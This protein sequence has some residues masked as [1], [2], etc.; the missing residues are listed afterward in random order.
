M[1][2]PS[3]GPPEP[4]LPGRR[5][6][7][8]SVGGP[9][10]R[11]GGVRV[12]VISAAP[13]VVLRL[14][15][16]KMAVVTLVAAVLLGT[17]PVVAAGAQGLGTEPG[18]TIVAQDPWLQ[19]DGRFT[20]QV[21]IT[22]PTDGYRLIGEVGPARSEMA[23]VL[24]SNPIEQDESHGRFI[25]L[26]LPAGTGTHS[27]S[28]NVAAVDTEWAPGLATDD[29]FVLDTGVYPLE[30]QVQDPDGEPVQRL[31]TH[32]PFLGGAIDNGVAP[33]PVG[34]LVDLRVGPQRTTDGRPRLDAA[35]TRR[36]DR[37][38][39]AL[40]AFADVGVSVQINPETISALVETRAGSGGGALS[41]LLQLAG[42][43][44]RRQGE[45]LNSTYVGFDEGAWLA[46][47]FDDVLRAELDAGFATLR[48][49]EFTTSRRL[50]ALNAGADEALMARCFDFGRDR[51][52]LA[53]P[54]TTANNQR[55]QPDGVSLGL[56]PQ[57]VVELPQQVTLPAADTAVEPLPRTA[58]LGSLDAYR[59]VAALLVDPISGRGGGAQ[60]RLGSAVDLDATFASTLLRLLAQRGPLR[61]T[62]ISDLFDQEQHYS[63]PKSWSANPRAITETVQQ[64]GQLLAGVNHRLAG[65]RSMLDV[66]APAGTEG[67][68]ETTGLRNTET[69]PAP[70]TATT[71]TTNSPSPLDQDDR[72]TP[73]GVTDE[74][75]PVENTLADELDARL[76]LVPAGG[77]SDAIANG[78][79]SGVAETVNAMI[80]G[81]VLPAAQSFRVTAHRATLPVV[82]LH[83]GQRPMRVALRLSSPEV[84]F[85]GPN[86]RIVVLQPGAN[87]VGVPIRTRRSGEF[88]VTIDVTSPDGA[89]LMGSIP[90]EVQSRAISG[91]GMF[92]SIGA[93]TF[94]LVWWAR[95][96]RRRRRVRNL[97]PIRHPTL[98]ANTSMDASTI[99]RGLEDAGAP[100]AGLEAAAARGR[101][102]P[103]A[104]RPST[105][106]SDQPLPPT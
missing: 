70:N 21:R 53:Q 6:R 84:E 46:G 59:V 14:V 48:G 97:D 90:V 105:G 5:P 44:A 87:D 99:D 91:V 30:L 1:T 80:S 81:V 17:F 32:L 58:G 68:P 71:P 98:P 93:L 16:V 67:R 49:E 101:G 75:D 42:A 95:N 39:D 85:E 9:V 60:L 103:T 50:V 28:V 62:T 78:I 61:A 23:E 26:D 4:A 82:L 19:R 33:R 77:I 40:A 88:N 45:I 86:P 29:L 35:S 34:V 66:P 102:S 63:E 3:Y 7:G 73:T 69:E 89:L 74:A 37:Q 92:L 20:L 64:R 15:V 25:E 22:V 100:V 18:L 31:I 65:L 41:G 54:A 47:Q 76:L 56:A 36:L 27:L 11:T 72:D 52:V 96:A 94:L 79:L 43:P 55:T 10:S 51:V 38:L 83:E 13:R 57:V 24:A 12:R 8:R 2:N 106:R 104:T